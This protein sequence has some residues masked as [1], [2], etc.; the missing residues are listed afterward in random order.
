MKLNRTMN[1]FYSL[2]EAAA[3]QHAGYGKKG[4]P[5]KEVAGVNT[6]AQTISKLQKEAREITASDKYNSVQK[7]I[8]I[9]RLAAKQKKIAQLCIKKYG[10]KFDY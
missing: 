8:L 3:K 9:D 6:A 7:R 5:S 1:D 4:K 2:K 10:S